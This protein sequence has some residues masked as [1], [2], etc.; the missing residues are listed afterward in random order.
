MGLPTE[1][2]NL[3]GY[4]SSSLLNIAKQLKSKKYSLVHGSYDDNVHVQHSMMLAR[5]LQKNDVEF[6]QSVN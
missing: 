5:I 3:A 6:S 2:D 4:N 1:N